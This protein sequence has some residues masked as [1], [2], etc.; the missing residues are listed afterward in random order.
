MVDEEQSESPRIIRF[1]LDNCEIAPWSD[2]VVEP[3]DRNT[4]FD[5]L[6]PYKG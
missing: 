5:D 4:I 2:V 3:V 1:D 6:K